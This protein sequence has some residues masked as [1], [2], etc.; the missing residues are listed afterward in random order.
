MNGRHSSLPARLQ[1]RNTVSARR[2]L[3]R[4]RGGQK[5]NQNARKHGFYSG[6]LEPSQWDEYWHA[7]TSE[8]V[9]PQIAF[10]RI[11][12]RAVL[13][14]RPSNHRALAQAAGLLAKLYASRFGFR[15]ND[16]RIFSRLVLDALENGKI[17]DLEN[18]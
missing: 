8:R 6:T 2:G 5:G 4:K 14:Q 17:H 13:R 18:L 12:L 1:D 16:R 3:K 7:V 10:I 9:D 11:Y 15:G